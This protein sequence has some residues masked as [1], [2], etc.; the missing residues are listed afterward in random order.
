METVLEKKIYDTLPE[1]LLHSEPYH[2]QKSGIPGVYEYYF[3]TEDVLE[4][5][6]RFAQKDVFNYLVNFGLIHDDLEEYA[7]TNKGRVY[8][9]VCT[10]V[11]A[12]E[13]FLKDH[14]EVKSL[15]FSGEFKDGEEGEGLSVRSKLFCRCAERILNESWEV[16]CRKNKVEIRKRKA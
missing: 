7:L 8:K 11:R 15:S 4:Y 5:E 16:V 14:P 10:V 13:D 12:V 6:V 2:F 9:I 3:M 1:L